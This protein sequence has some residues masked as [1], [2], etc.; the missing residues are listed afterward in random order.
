MA[1]IILSDKEYA[2]IRKD[3]REWYGL[4]PNIRTL[5]KFLRGTRVLGEIASYGG[6]VTGVDT[7]ERE[8]VA[9]I[10][11]DKLTGRSWPIGATSQKETKEFFRLLKR[12]AKRYKIRLE[13]EDSYNY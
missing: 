11:A 12:G 4:N 1:R 6:R 2:A 13:I 5:R 7:C 8:E 9:D 3:I 10:F